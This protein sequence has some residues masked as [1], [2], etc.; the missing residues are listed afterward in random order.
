MIFNNNNN[1]FKIIKQL[2]VNQR[3]QFA[4]LEKFKGNLIYKM[5]N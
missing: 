3:N 4:K 2:T 1:S 5:I